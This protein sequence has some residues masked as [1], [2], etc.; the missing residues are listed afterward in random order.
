MDALVEPLDA[1]A[2]VGQPLYM[3]QVAARLEREQ[4]VLGCL[5]D[6]A[7]HRVRA[8]QAVEGGIDLDGVEERRVVLEP[9]ARRQPL[10]VY[11]AAPVVVVPARAADV[12]GLHVRSGT[13]GPHTVRLSVLASVRLSA[14]MK[15]TFCARASRRKRLSRRI[16][17]WRSIC[18]LPITAPMKRKTIGMPRNRPPKLSAVPTTAPK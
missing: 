11:A 12:N 3:G 13:S 18:S 17:C 10:R 2:E 4:E 7:G 16:R 14:G 1:L 6:P 15:S 9:A 5:L 8:G